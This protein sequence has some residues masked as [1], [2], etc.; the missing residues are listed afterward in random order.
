MWGIVFGLAAMLMLAVL[1][2]P[3]AKRS[4]IPYTV[5]IALLGIGL[6]FLFQYLGGGAAGDHIAGP[7]EA[8]SH[9][10]GAIWDQMIA[11]IGGLRI[12]SDVILFIFLPALVFES[13]LSLD[14]RKL[15]AD[16]RS[17][18]FLAVIG[19]LISTAIV[20]AA[21]AGYAG[22]A[23]I[24]SL[25]LGAIVSATDPVAVIALFKDLNAPKRLTVLV[26]GESLFNDATAIVAASILL[27]MLTQQAS[28]DLL[29]G[30]G[31]FLI[32]FIGGVAV[33]VAIARP[34]CSL[35]GA[36]R[37]EPQIILTLTISLPFLT[38]VIAEHFLHVSG[39]MAVVAGGLTVGS[40]GRRLIPPQSFREIEHSWGQIAF[41]ATSLIFILVGLAT[42]RLLG[43]NA[44]AYWDDVLVLVAAA[45]LARILI[46]YGFLPLMSRFAGG[47]AVNGAYKAIMVWGGLRGAVSLALA[48]IVIE[49]PAIDE[50]ARVFVGVMVT[51]FV[52]FTLLFQ[53]TTIRFLMALLGLDKLS[54]RD[55]ALRDRSL[56]RALQSVKSGLARIAAF[57]EV[58]DAEA[59]PVLTRYERAIEAAQARAR[60]AD[61]ITA[62]DWTRVGLAMA[63]AQERQLYLSHFGEGYASARQ[64]R[65]ALGRLDDVADF[66]KAPALDWP[67]A[68]ARGVAFRRLFAIG[69]ALQ[70]R[71]GVTAVL[72]RALA[73]RFGVL[74]YM[75]EVLRAQK[76]AGLEEILAMLPDGARQDFRALF[77]Q[78]HQAVAQS[79][80]A[81]ALQY[82]EYAAALKRRNLALAGLRLEEAAYARLR[83]QSVIGPEIHNDLMKRVGASEAHI[84]KLPP[85]RLRL[86][87]LA[88]LAKAPLFAHLP[89]SRRRRIARLLR[90]R[91][92]TPG[93]IFVRRGEIGEEM[94][95]IA[96]GAVRVIL[97]NKTIPLGTGDFVGELALI[98]NKPRN[99]DVEALGFCSLLVLHK[100]DFKAFLR[101]NPE[102]RER[103]RQAAIERLGG[104]AQIDI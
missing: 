78:R 49:S 42:P 30:L 8:P 52:L 95:F 27:G 72:G 50:E 65:D 5:V 68:I 20:G 34:A 67:A 66:L 82:P 51:S 18:L 86:D 24:V 70:R 7:V 88:L 17:I 4:N 97:D 3:I 101:K 74:H 41:W 35:M 87:P 38:F 21:I 33:G 91:F 102:L 32:V 81:L 28:P 44:L 39:V 98:T 13:A 25:L 2:A 62:D 93:E 15:L 69:L 76:E 40:I 57:N 83:D 36:F 75:R 29:A 73:R 56:S 96:S 79:Y 103:I 19:V 46:I 99:A 26:E 61:S 14:L 64:L 90:S 45:T 80:D 104:D 58:A 31:E 43:A 84:L 16:I 48:L 6:G 1:M 11:A 89:K 60:N 10:G 55:Q 9:G 59:A 12:T 23:L 63:L 54:A 53:A 94:Y 71:A 22:A 92:A 47:Q 77:E 85:L 37:R 100:N